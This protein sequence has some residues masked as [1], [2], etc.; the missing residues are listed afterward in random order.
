MDIQE[1]RI[2]QQILPRGFIGWIM[3]WVMPIF[4]DSI[5]KLVYPVLDLQ[6]QDSLLEVACGSGHF[7]KKYA[8]NVKRIAG[9]DLSDVMIKMA[10][11]KNKDRIAAG[12]AEFVQGEAINLPWKDN[13]FSVVTSIGSFVYF[14]KPLESTR[15]M[16]RVLYPGGR[17]VVSIEWNAEDE[18]DHS[19]K[20][21]E[22]GIQIHSEEDI[23]SIMMQAGFSDISFTYK[24]DFGIAKIMIVRAVK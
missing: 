23:R 19:K 7:L 6:P 1:K 16:Y 17:T 14:S 20:I 9:L 15:E 8:S 24:K 5:Y 10:K 21:K 3:G 22:W 18:V 2:P 13:T 12:T 4:H 11:R